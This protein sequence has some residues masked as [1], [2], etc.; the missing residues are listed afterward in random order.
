MY[1]SETKTEKFVSTTP[2]KKKTKYQ[3]MGLGVLFSPEAHEVY[4]IS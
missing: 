2:P 4:V 1:V 3:R